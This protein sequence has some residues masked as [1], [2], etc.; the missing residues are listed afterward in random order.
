MTPVTAGAPYT[1][2]PEPRRWSA[3]TLAA[4]V[5][6]GLLLFL[7]IGVHWQS[8]QPVAVEAEVWDM[9]TMTAAPPRPAPEPEPE[10]PPPPPKRAEPEPEPLPRPAPPDI[11]LERAK[12]KKKAEEL[13]RKQDQEQLAAQNEAKELEAKKKADKLAKAKR[14][15]QEKKL[16]EAQRKEALQRMMAAAG[17]TASGEAPKSTAPRIDSGYVASLT[18]KIKGNIAYSGS[19]GVPGNPR[20][21]YKIEQ[22]PTGEIISVRKIRGS[23]IPEYDLA[24]ENAI[25]KSSPLPRKKDGTVERSLELGFNLKDLQ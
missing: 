4:A 12:E 10:P 7:W 14:E 6:A 17:S 15:A 25:A 19:L 3:L 13:K 23:G 18:A 11:K 8:T 20:A 5:H 22:L 1:V 24:V 16:V 9:K 21:Q 2:P